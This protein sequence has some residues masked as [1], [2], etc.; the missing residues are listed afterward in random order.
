LVQSIRAQRDW[1][2]DDVAQVRV[3]THSLSR[4]LLGRDTSSRLAAMFSLPFVVS[5]AVV[6]G[7][8]DPE[9]MRPGSQPFLAARAFMV[10]VEAEV[11]DSFDAYLPHQRCTEVSITFT[12]GDHISLGQSN[13][14]GDADHFPLGADDI[15]QKLVTLIG[16]EDTTTVQ[17]VVRALPTADDA[18]SALAAL[19]LCQTR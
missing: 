11:D 19:A 3:A 12:D 15:Q 13:P 8:V 5:T 17:N 1:R 6:N 10:R 16:L 4:A 9:T 2:A 14:I 7:S 18:T